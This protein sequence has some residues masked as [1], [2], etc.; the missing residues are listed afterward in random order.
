MDSDVAWY[1]DV[2]AAVC[3]P[4]SAW[5]A[6]VP[7]P[8]VRHVPAWCRGIPAGAAA[9]PGEHRADGVPVAV[10]DDSLA[11]ASRRARTLPPGQLAQRAVFCHPR[12]TERRFRRDGQRLPAR[13]R[14]SLRRR[15]HHARGGTVGVRRRPSAAGYSGRL[16]HERLR[17]RRGQHAPRR[18]APAASECRFDDSQ[19]CRRCQG[20][21]IGGSKRHGA[22]VR[23][24]C[25]RAWRGR[26]CSGDARG[27]S[28][29]RRHA[30]APRAQR[31]AKIAAAWRKP[32]RGH[33]RGG[34]LARPE[35]QP[36]PFRGPR[37]T[38]P[39]RPAGPR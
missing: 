21:G 30:T 36:Q 35:R 8:G 6:R 5:H 13:K 15:L 19:G 3:A 33:R 4:S 26:S 18:P 2:C 17:A 27:L 20:H 11:A 32:G 29:A 14:V 38:E 7:G 24:R 9:G 23:P 25:R 34:A 10:T 1:A 12:G 28:R 16:R 37:R 31:E 22:R 39:V